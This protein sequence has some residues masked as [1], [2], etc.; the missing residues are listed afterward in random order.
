MMRHLENRL[1]VSYLVK[2]SALW[3]RLGAIYS[4]ELTA[5]FGAAGLAAVPLFSVVTSHQL[6]ST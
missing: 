1:S 3:K 2:A 4:R 5:C 6:S